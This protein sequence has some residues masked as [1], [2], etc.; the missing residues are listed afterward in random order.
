MDRSRELEQTPVG[1]L[2]WKYFV[3][4]IIG[5][6]A[7]TIYNIVDRIYIGRGVGALA[8]S[9]LSITFPIMII[10]M[11]FGMLVG[12]GASS[13]VSIRLGQQNKGEAERILGNA[14]ILLLLIS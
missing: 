14:F 10:A 1:K 9:G 5:V 11:A 7:N 13:L 6:M 2:L 8:L 12:M 4:A 3:P